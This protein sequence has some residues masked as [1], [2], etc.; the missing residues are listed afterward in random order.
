MVNTIIKLQSNNSIQ[1]FELKYRVGKSC[2]VLSWFAAI[3]SILDLN[4]TQLILNAELNFLSINYCQNLESI[5]IT[6]KFE[7]N[8]TKRVKE[9]FAIFQIIHRII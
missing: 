2:L 7:I 9:Y 1:E 4:L 3:E 5:M 8:Y 6:I